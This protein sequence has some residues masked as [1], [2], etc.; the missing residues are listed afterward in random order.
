MRQS[1]ILS[2]LQTG[3]T[4]IKVV[5]NIPKA[6]VTDPTCSLPKDVQKGYT[7]K[8]AI[9]VEVN[10]LVVVPHDKNGLAICQVVE[11]H[12]EPELD[13]DAP[14][15]YKWVIDKIDL[16]T[17]QHLLKAEQKGL[18][19][20]RKLEVQKRKADILEGLKGLHGDSLEALEYNVNQYDDDAKASTSSQNDE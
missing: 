20:L 11:V 1:H 9:D 14:Y 16:T 7:F 17:Y 2:M 13:L 6:V 15:D 12:K 10:D 18:E 8:T 3:Y 4:T 5:Y 19:G